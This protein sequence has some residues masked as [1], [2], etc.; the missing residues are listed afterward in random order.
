MFKGIGIVLGGI[1]VGAVGVEV[2]RKK[3]PNAMDGIYAK[4]RKV[5]SDAKQ[6]FKN[7]YQGATQPKA[8][9]SVSA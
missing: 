3:Y 2:I 4:T 8:A 5:A 6:A 7:G 9:A 1:F